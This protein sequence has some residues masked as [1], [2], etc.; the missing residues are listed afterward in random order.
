MTIPIART[1]AVAAALTPGGALA[2]CSDDDKPSAAEYR[3][4]V[5]AI[6]TAGNE[7]LDTLF[8]NSTLGPDATEP[9]LVE[10]LEQILGEIDGQLDDIDA[11][12]APGTLADGVD[13]WLAE[14]RATSAEVRSGGA[15]FFEQQASGVNPFADVNA[16]A[17]ELG[18]DACG[19]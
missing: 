5:N 9:Q 19:G 17:L 8:S 2:G 18:F 1:L 15:A 11:L 7:R 4:E 16:E 13:A 10:M 3:T 12:D 6:C 14:S